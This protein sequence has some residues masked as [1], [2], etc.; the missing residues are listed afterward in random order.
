[1]SLVSVFLCFMTQCNDATDDLLSNE[2]VH[3][4]NMK[5][6]LETHLKLVNIQLRT[7]EAARC[8]LSNVH[9]ERAREIDLICYGVPC[10]GNQNAYVRVWN[11]PPQK[12]CE[13]SDHLPFELQACA[14]AKL[15]PADPLGLLTNECDDALEVTYHLNC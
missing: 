11:F 1:M 14:T 13:S 4:D 15:S 3:L 7:L 6:L 9:C 2:T 5:K 10:T 8:R 12:I